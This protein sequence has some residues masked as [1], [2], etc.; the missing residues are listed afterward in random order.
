MG[1]RCWGGL[2][3]GDPPSRVPRAAD[4]IVLRFAS[5]QLSWGWVPQWHV[6]AQ[7]L[8]PQTFGALGPTVEASGAAVTLIC[9]TD[10]LDGHR[11]VG[12]GGQSG[13]Q[14][15]LAPRDTELQGRGEGALT[16]R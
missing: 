5:Q 10:T 13:A 1:E 11:W 6:P 12:T 2:S 7:T 4:S 14:Q 9:T 8:P 3:S 15:D 16:W